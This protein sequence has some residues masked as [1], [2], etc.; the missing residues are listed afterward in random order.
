MSSEGGDGAL[1]G[2]VIDLCAFL[3]ER[4]EFGGVRVLVV[5]DVLP[6]SLA[7]AR[8]ALGAAREALQLLWERAVLRRA[9]RCLSQVAWLALALRWPSRAGPHRFPHRF[10]RACPTPCARLRSIE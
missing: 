1:R 10:A 2:R 9:L 3:V 7:Q 4:C 8:E 6:E 5:L